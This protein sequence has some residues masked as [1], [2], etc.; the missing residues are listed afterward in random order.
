[1]QSRWS[2]NEANALTTQYAR[3]GI[4]VDLAL[5]VY[6]SRLLG[7]DSRLVL[8]GGGNTSVKTRAHDLSGDET[9]VLCVKGS[10]WDMGNIEPPGLPAVRMAP[11]LKLRSRETLSDEDMVQH[12]RAYLLDPGAPNPSVETL[13]H[14]FLPHKFIDHTHSTAVLSLADQPNSPALCAE[15][16]GRRMGQVPYIMPG[17]ALAKKAAEVFEQDPSVEGLILLKHGIFTFGET[18]REAYERMI[19]M[20]SLAEARLAR[21]RTSVFLPA[22]L[23]AETAPLASVAPI[24]RGACSMAEGDDWRR[25]ILDFRTSPAILNYVNGA[26]VARY[27]TQG[28]VTPD[29]TIRTKNYPLIAPTVA[30][31]FREAAWAAADRFVADYRAYFSRNN[32]GQATPK[33]ML[34][35][36]PRVI[37]APGLGL[38]GLG[39]SKKDAAIAADIAENTV[40]TITD[41]EAIGRFEA[42][43]ESDLFDM[44]YWSLEQAKLGAAKEKPLAGQIAVVTGGAGAIGAA[45]ARLFRE[46]GAEVAVLDLDPGKPDGGILGV[47]CDVTDATSIKA[48]FDRV[49][50][51]F[52]GV[53]IVIS[54]AGAAWTGTIGAVDEAILRQSFELNFFA[55]QRVAQSAVGIM[56]AQG[57]G[58]CLL[59]NVSKQA[60]NP[61]PD[62]GPYGLP[63]A[64]TLFLARQYAVDYGAHGIRSNA[65]NADRIRSGVLTP[66]MIA[67]RSTARGLTEA[68]YMGG[69]L[70]GREVTAKDVA[71]AFLHQALSLKTTAGVTTVDGGNI[72]AALR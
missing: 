49:V 62:F 4:G 24:L 40:A 14:A 26:D 53:D 29:H 11:L 48:A 58:G 39:R 57:T 23:P 46:N 25:M 19:E 27:A 30:D 35:P 6:T 60:V 64:A 33:T 59:F 37:L 45:T 61:G 3:Q 28:V 13:L 72:A 31:G 2:D 38:F 18:A 7:Q 51:T 17:F 10:G 65:V 34:D 22:A 1:M 70:L 43:P 16:Y 56:L 12:Q 15:I 8:H 32:A 50:E 55:H 42:L 21:E 20:V 54:N 69:N 5:R 47:A 41:A 9:D 71:Q 36:L 66:E 67:Q 44:E 52:G 63:K 68:D